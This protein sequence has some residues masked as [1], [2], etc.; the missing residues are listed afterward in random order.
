MAASGTSN[1]VP[2]ITRVILS[3]DGDAKLVLSSQ[4]AY[5][6]ITKKTINVTMKSLSYRYP[7]FS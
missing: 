7:V 5:R 2:N 4:F 6:K 1:E 3:L